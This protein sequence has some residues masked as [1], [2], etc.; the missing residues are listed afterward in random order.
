MSEFAKLPLTYEVAIPNK[1]QRLKELIVYI[2]D[3]C[4]GNEKFGATMLNKILWAA[5]FIS[6]QDK[7]RPITGE[8]YQRLERGPAPRRLRPIRSEMEANGDI[9]VRMTDYRG[10]VQHRTIALRDAD[11]SIFSG[12]EIALVDKVIDALSTMNGKELSDWSHGRAWKTR[13]N[14]DPMPYESTFLSDEYVTVGDI[15]RTEQL[16][17]KYGWGKNGIAST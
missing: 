5:D 15:S 8:V 10:R 12:D 17:K 16:I 1:E 4:A 9:R 6:Y 13:N 7:G 11:L 3:K 2:S 14:Q